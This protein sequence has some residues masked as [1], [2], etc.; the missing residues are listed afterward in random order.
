[1]LDSSATPNLYII[2]DDEDYLEF[3]FDVFAATN[4]NVQG[5]G[6]AEGFLDAYTESTFECVLSDFQMPGMN[7]IEL[8]KNLAIDN[9]TLPVIIV[10][11]FA[12]IP[13]AVNAVRNGAFDFI[14]KP[15]SHQLLR[16]RVYDA[17]AISG[18]NKLIKKKVQRIDGLM[19]TLTQREIVVLRFALKGEKNKNIAHKL[20]IS[21]KTVEVHRNNIK[22]KFHARSFV[23]LAAH[24]SFYRGVKMDRMELLN[25]LNLENDV[26]SPIVECRADDGSMHCV[27]RVKELI[28]SIDE[29]GEE[30]CIYDK[31][32]I[33]H[34]LEE[35]ANSCPWA[36]DNFCRAQLILSNIMG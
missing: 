34:E 18:L 11:G 9:P 16:R 36:S 28:W 30:V 24:I 26:L 35:I 25:R 29:E 13:S 7:G 20:G 31:M 33:V 6:S 21:E 8:Q 5:F 4:S 2:D 3:L 22:N 1:M 27:H 10:T 32:K 14:E 23:E 12:D 19:G 17:F 15:C